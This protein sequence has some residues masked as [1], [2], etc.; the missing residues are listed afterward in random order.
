[1]ERDIA[2]DLYEIL[3]KE[4]EERFSKDATI[5][6]LYKKIQ[7]HK[8][9]YNDANEFAVRTGELCA[10]VMQKNITADVLPD[11]KMY[12]NIAERTVRPMLE[13][14]Y[15]IV[16]Q[17]CVQVQKDLNE[18]AGLKLKALKAEINNDRVAG[19]VDKLSD[20]ELF[21]DVAYMLV[22]PTVNFTQSVVDDHIRSNIEAQA[23]AG[24]N[25]TIS[26]KVA[27][28]C[29]D[30]CQ[31]LAGTY[32]YG[33][34]PEDIFRKHLYCRCVVLYDPKTGKRQNVHSKKWYDNEEVA[35]EEARKE[36][37][38]KQRKNQISLAEARRIHNKRLADGEYGLTLSHQQYLKHRHGTAQFESYAKTRQQ[39]G[40][41]PQGRLLISEE[42]AQ[43]LIF[44]YAGKGT[45]KTTMSGNVENKEFV[46][47]GYT[48]GEYYERGAWH[49]TER[50]EIIYGSK[51]AHV[52]P[53]KD[54]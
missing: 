5:Q 13:N 30:W 21:E 46:T 26:R 36:T 51:T 37:Q 28:N 45:P 25:P 41:T 15:D 53:V 12:Y 23:R 4:F 24:L 50:A 22:E 40:K 1:M 11:G 54:L 52:V 42:E 43:K 20:A 27:G 7:E 10:E 48:I 9:D 38:E 35:L 31:E 14:N 32:T 17:I 47:A 19:I 18:N 49:K 29:C 44:R 33:E 6:R 39:R 8:A 3:A 16:S 34:H 2:P